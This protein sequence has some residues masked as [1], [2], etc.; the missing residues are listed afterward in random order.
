[1]VIFMSMLAS[2]VAKEEQRNMNMIRQYTKEL[3]DLPKGSIR[4]KTIKGNVYYYLNYRDGEK[5]VSK[6]IGK[7]EE[8]V[9]DLKQ[10]IERRIQI[11]KILK[12]LKAER[13]EIVKMEGRL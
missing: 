8:K 11:E 13:K 3:E 12:Q 5:V 1:M 10:R 9:L 2:V 7:D 6:Y 4:V